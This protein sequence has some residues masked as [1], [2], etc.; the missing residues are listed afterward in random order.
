MSGRAVSRWQVGAA[1]AAIRLYQLTF[2]A[3]IGRACRH[4]PTC[5]DYASEAIERHGLWI[6]GWMG[7]ARLC[8]CHPKGTHGYD[9]V[10]ASLPARAHPLLP[11]RYGTWRGP[12]A[13]EEGSS[14]G[15]GSGAGL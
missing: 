3:L 11:W 5:S 2:S 13:C 9:P 14:S 4:L 12:L 7:A 1:R 8:R 15:S 10:P 6:G